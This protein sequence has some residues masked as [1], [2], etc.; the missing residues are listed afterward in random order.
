MHK[1]M[2]P[3]KR[4][5]QF[6]GRTG[7]SEYWWFQLFIVI[8]SSPLYILSAYAGHTGSQ[9]LALT[10][11][12][13]SLLLWLAVALPCIAATVRRLHDTDRSGWW[14]LLAFVPFASLALLVFMLLPGNAG[15]NRF[16]APVPHV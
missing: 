3:L 5:A 14:L 9:G 4:Y 7:R 13:L 8:V 16:G 12:G 10:A 15:D 1:M 6:S 11:S 2:M